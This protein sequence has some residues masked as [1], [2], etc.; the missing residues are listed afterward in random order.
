MSTP[1]VTIAICTYNR[2]DLLP[3]CLATLKSQSISKEAWEIIIVDNNSSDE[4]AN[5]AKSFIE[6]NKG[7]LNIRYVFEPQQGLSFA[8]NRCVSESA[9]EFI[10]FID[11]DVE[12]DINYVLEIVNFFNRNK[13]AIGLGGKTITKYVDGEKPKWISKYLYGLVGQTDH[14]DEVK[15][16][17]KKM[18][19]PIG[20][21]MTY[22][23]EILLQVGGFNNELKNRSDDKYINS[24]VVKL[25]NEIYYNP[26]VYSR[27]LIDK[28]RLTYD[29]FKKLYTKT[30]SEEIIRAT[31]EGKKWQTVL[32]QFVKLG[33]GLGLFGMY[34]LRGKVIQGKYIFLSQY[35]A[36]KGC[37]SGV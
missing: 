15:Q 6:E 17:T 28:A 33:A 36:L 23:K 37:L 5:I 12:L 1:F 20:C 26:K 14:G 8:R 32:L 10:T 30:G 19:Y 22:K 16:F 34:A 13:S 18:K 29:S 9:G 7:N 11:D 21:N 35:Y 2:E 27:H 25:S 31:K 3:Y 24:Q 4:T